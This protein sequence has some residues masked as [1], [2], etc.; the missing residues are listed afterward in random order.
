MKH[1][2]S[3]EPIHSWFGLTYSAYLVLQRTA[4]QTMPR[5]WQSKFVALLEEMELHLD[6]SEAPDSYDVRAKKDGRYVTDPYR[7]YRRGRAT[8]PVRGREE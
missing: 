2:D 3:I 8:F 7:D 4:L 5:E 1:A 6:T